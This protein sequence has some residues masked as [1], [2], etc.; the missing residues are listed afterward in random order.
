MGEGEG[1]MG[2]GEGIRN[3]KV[4]KLFLH[5][6][7]YSL[8]IPEEYNNIHDVQNSSICLLTLSLGEWGKF[9]ELVPNPIA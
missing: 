9:L 2:G 3:L 7:L 5:V 6:Y 8:D 1:G 4:S